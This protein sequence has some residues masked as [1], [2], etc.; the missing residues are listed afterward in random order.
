MSNFAFR[1]AEFRAVAEST[2]KGGG[3]IMGDPCAA[4]FTR[5]EEIAKAREEWEGMLG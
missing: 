4:C 2:G 1:P 5:E 3:Q